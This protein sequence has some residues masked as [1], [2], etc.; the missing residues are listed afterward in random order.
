MQSI[1]TSYINSSSKHTVYQTTP[2]KEQ[3]GKKRN[4]KCHISIYL[5]LYLYMCVCQI[6]DKCNLPKNLSNYTEKN[7]HPILKGEEGSKTYQ[8]ERIYK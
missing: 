4:C 1:Q 7:R 2:R 8:I 5:Y 3:K 6:Y